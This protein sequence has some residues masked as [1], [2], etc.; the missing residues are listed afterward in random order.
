MVSRGGETMAKERGEAHLVAMLSR[1]RWAM[2]T[3]TA[4]LSVSYVLFEH[5]I[6]LR[7][8][9]NAHIIRELLF[10]G[11][12]GP[13]L[14][15]LVLEWATEAALARHRA[16]EEL[17][18][19]NRQLAGLN[20]ISEAVNRSL[21]L[22]EVLDEALDRV[23]DLLQVD[24]GEVRLL[25][26]GTLRLESYRGLSP[27]FVDADRVVAL[28][29]CLC[30]LA[31]YHSRPF[32]VNDLRVAPA[33]TRR[34]CLDDGLR[35]IMCVPVIS[36]TRVVGVIHVGCR[37]PRAFSP[38]EEAFLAAIG[39]QIGMAIENASLYARVKA[40][41]RELE[42]RVRERTIELERARR[43][44]AQKAQQLQKLLA[45]T[46]QI[47]E[48]ERARIA[49]D[50]HNGVIQ[51]I[52]GALYEVQAAKDAAT[53]NPDRMHACLEA[54]LELIQQIEAE[55]RRTIYDLRPPILDAKGLIPALRQ[56]AFRYQDLTG[57][58]CSL[59]VSGA[60]RRLSTDAE[61]AIYR[62]V[63]EALHNI[64]CHARATM[65][66]VLVRFGPRGLWLM[67]RDDGQGFDPQAVACHADRHLGLVGM[68]E[69]IQSVGGHLEIEAEPGRGTSI[70]IRI[71]AQAFAREEVR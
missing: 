63:Q 62:V 65:A 34:A 33:V 31:A 52:A 3:A 38:Q 6:L 26:E 9:L 37:Q 27:G 42:A 48:R 41:N 64:Q 44:I 54:A 21:D 4:L 12:V 23:M 32:T 25:R 43:E 5:R 56:Y 45:E 29:E 39:R 40:L 68:R 60:P 55:T 24:V 2:P 50:M 7:S 1:L 47:Q 16:R 53:T 61:V 30:G 57:I 69:R 17:R 51:L 49:H 28:G 71:P 66:E 15:G 36:K 59:H 8:A 18:E 35:S 70:V 13:F 14:A 22:Q 58:P 10:F 19:R 67:I 20:S 11:L 46:V